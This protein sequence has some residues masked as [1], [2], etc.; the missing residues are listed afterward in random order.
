[1]PSKIFSFQLG[2]IVFAAA[3][4]ISAISQPLDPPTLYSVKALSD[5]TIEERW[6]N[7]DSRTQGYL[8]YRRQQGV[9]QFSLLGLIKGRECDTNHNLKASTTYIYALRAAAGSDTSAFSNS[10]SATTKPATWKPPAITGLDWDYEKRNIIV[11]YYDSA[12]CED[13]IKMF[14]SQDDASF[15]PI[16]TVLVRRRTIGADSLFLHAPSLDSW[17]RF[18]LV[19]YS[20]TDR[21]VSS[22]S[23][24]IFSLDVNP[25]IANAPKI[26]VGQKIGSIPI[27]YKGWAVK[28]GNTI[29][30]LEKN[31][32]D[33]SYSI[34]DIS[35]QQHP[36][37][38]EYRKTSLP[39]TSGSSILWPILPIKAYSGKAQNLYVCSTERVDYD[40]F[41]EILNRYEMDSVGS[42]K[43]IWKTRY[44]IN[45][46]LAPGIWAMSD[47]SILSVKEGSDI[48]SVMSFHIFVDTVIVLDGQGLGSAYQDKI[49]G[50]NYIGRMVFSRFEKVHSCDCIRNDAQVRDYRIVSNI[51]TCEIKR[52]N[53]ISNVNNLDMVRHVDDY[54]LIN[55]TI[56]QYYE[57]FFDRQKMQVVFVH[58][59]SLTIYAADTVPIAGTIDRDVK[60]ALSQKLALHYRNGILSTRITANLA[61]PVMIELRDIA[62]RLVFV[63]M[64]NAGSDG[65][66]Q[67]KI[68]NLA[69]GVYLVTLRS[70]TFIVRK[71]VA[72]HR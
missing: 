37:F 67:C 69:S 70:S 14:V 26:Y 20:G 25:L 35:D 6:R 57:A 60:T 40:F 17:F 11:Y 58:D 28:K 8:L 10:D 49:S 54:L 72:I 15:K 51:K 31:S 52:K 33:S 2:I 63:K 47:S 1:M 5:S 27:S 7:N 71:S 59:S 12:N 13:S 32:P 18:Y 44:W 41:Y 36:R 61:S 56:K 48:H 45:T 21:L 50:F 22:I 64:V 24:N 29:G 34:I 23:D 16:D 65:S 4:P 46:G 42:L 68:G 43:N 53:I 66:V 55:N 39:V 9:E 19:A 38:K 30:V 62:G 3:L